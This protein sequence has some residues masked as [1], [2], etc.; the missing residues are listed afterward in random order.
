MAMVYGD[1]P[2]AQPEPSRE[3]RL[4]SAING[5]GVNAAT[6]QSIAAELATGGISAVDLL[7]RAEAFARDSS[8]KLSE[9]GA[10]LAMPFGDAR[11]L[12]LVDIYRAEGAYA[13]ALDN[14][15][16][17]LGIIGREPEMAASYTRASRELTVRPTPPRQRI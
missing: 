17:M 15:A 16:T 2:T 12:D 10:I 9:V 13:R 8:G 6:Q 4:L 14:A 7:K 5:F 3:A 1:Q 11:V